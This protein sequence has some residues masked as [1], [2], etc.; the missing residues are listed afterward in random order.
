[1]KIL[2]LYIQTLVSYQGRLDKQL[3]Q[4]KHKYLCLELRLIPLSC[5]YSKNQVSQKVYTYGHTINKTNKISCYT[6]KG[7]AKVQ[8]LRSTSMAHTKGLR[9]MN[10]L[11]GHM[12]LQQEPY[13]TFGTEM[14]GEPKYLQKKLVSV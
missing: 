8:K 14:R 1:M 11:E 6:K 2:Y 12:P 4:T 13:L 10:N 3:T 9:T 5:S 7:H